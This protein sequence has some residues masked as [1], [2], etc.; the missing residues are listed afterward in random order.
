MRIT[1]LKIFWNYFYRLNSPPNAFN[2]IFY[3]YSAPCT[4][5]KKNDS[6]KNLKFVQLSQE[7]AIKFRGFHL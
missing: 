3:V 6:D 4:E 7:F 5:E 1:E 2:R